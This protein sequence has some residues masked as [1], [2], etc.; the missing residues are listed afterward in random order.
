MLITKLCQ[1]PMLSMINLPN[2]QQ[3]SWNQCE[4]P[5]GLDVNTVATWVA[6]LQNTGENNEFSKTYIGNMKSYNKRLWKH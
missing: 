6:F 1:V 4:H 5:S 2:F 3:F